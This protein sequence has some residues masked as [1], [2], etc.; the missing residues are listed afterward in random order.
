M[1]GIDFWEEF[2]S[3]PLGK[4]CIVILLASINDLLEQYYGQ[5]LIFHRR[6]RK[7]PNLVKDHVDLCHIFGS[8]SSPQSTPFSFQT[9]SKLDLQ[10]LR[11]SLLMSTLADRPHTKQACLLRCALLSRN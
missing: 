1:D 8:S 4:H 5:N 7:V 10:P 2:G 9:L 6:S 11:F 3:G